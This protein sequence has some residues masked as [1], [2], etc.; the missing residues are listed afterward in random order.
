[1]DPIRLL[2]L[3]ALS[4]TCWREAR[5]ESVLG[6]L[7]VCQVVENRVRDPRWPDTYVGVITQ[8]AQFSA[9]NKNDPNALL[10]PTEL[11][12][13]WPECVAVAESVLSTPTPFTTANHYH[14]QSVRPTWARDD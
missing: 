6:K 2:R 14:A 4:L 10:F 9:F 12:R 7:L 5:G 11:D 1:M 3:F 8:A 13:S